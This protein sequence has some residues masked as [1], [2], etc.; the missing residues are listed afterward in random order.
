MSQPD[1]ALPRH[2]A[3]DKKVSPTVTPQLQPLTRNLSETGK[4]DSADTLT[5]KHDSE[6]YE[7]NKGTNLN[8]NLPPKTSSYYLT[9]SSQDAEAYDSDLSH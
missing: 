3:S 1:T 2:G 8:D 5:D 4:H 6:N 7:V 9:I